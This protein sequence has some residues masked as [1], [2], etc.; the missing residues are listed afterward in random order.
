M[1]S[2]QA[3]PASSPAPAA[4]GYSPDQP[5]R[6]FV[7]NIG[8]QVA[9][10]PKIRDEY[11]DKIAKSF[12]DLDWIANPEDI[13][14][15]RHELAQPWR[16]AIIK[17]WQLEYRQTKKL[18]KALSRTSSNLVNSV[19]TGLTDDVLESIEL[20]STGRPTP[21]GNNKHRMELASISNISVDATGLNNWLRLRNCVNISSIRL[22]NQTDLEDRVKSTQLSSLLKH[23]LQM[24]KEHSEQFL[25][26]DDTTN[27]MGAST[28]HEVFETARTTA[29]EL[30][31][32]LDEA[33]KGNMVELACRDPETLSLLQELLNR[34]FLSVTLAFTYIEARWT[35]FYH[36][37]AMGKAHGKT[38]ME[39]RKELEQ[40]GR[41]M[42]TRIRAAGNLLASL[43]PTQKWGPLQ[44]LRE[45]AYLVASKVPALG[46][47]TGANTIH[48]QLNAQRYHPNPNPDPD[49]DMGLA[50]PRTEENNATYYA[51]PPAEAG[52]NGTKDA[53]FACPLDKSQPLEELAKVIDAHWATRPAQGALV[54]INAATLLADTL[55]ALPGIRTST[56][57]RDWNIPQIH[58]RFLQQS[59]L[60]GADDYLAE[61]AHEPQRLK[62]TR[63][64]GKVMEKVQSL[65]ENRMDFN[66]GPFIRLMEGCEPSNIAQPMRCECGKT[67]NMGRDPHKS[68]L[69]HLNEHHTA[70]PTSK[71]NWRTYN[72]Q[73]EPPKK[74]H[75]QGAAS[76]TSQGRTL[77]PGGRDQKRTRLHPGPGDGYNRGKSYQGR[78]H[79]T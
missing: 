34:T 19:L 41:P 35:I 76:T 45:L 39:M 5:I 54:T 73:G 3:T 24:A 61:A 14:K 20:G 40:D 38:I 13:K 16:E 32:R 71:Q 50:A 67:F 8:L 6:N 68:F 43:H 78:H 70:H 59:T 66:I 75:N 1:D 51:Y 30:I 42:S 18:R 46:S 60:I 29:N 74:R 9:L 72:P 10:F 57:V 56:K 77:S 22:P 65:R 2:Q 53:P 11:C 7:D 12:A 62:A 52:I 79:H 26:V 55:R 58:Q 37:S 47:F 49:L 27:T 36:P 15:L 17:N 28:H 21:T 63:W 48:R 33:L 4:E 44:D 23:S 64:K 31:P 69:T 25:Q